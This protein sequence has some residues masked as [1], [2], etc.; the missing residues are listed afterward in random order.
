M[1]NNGNSKIDNEIIVAIG[2]IQDYL[3][4]KID[5]GGIK[6]KFSW[7]DTKKQV[8][9]TDVA[10]SDFSTSKN[11]YKILLVNPGKRK[12]YFVMDEDVNI[13]NLKNLF[14]KLASGD[15]R[16]KMFPKNEFPELTE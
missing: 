11:G 8:K 9:F 1:N 6:Y 14:D 13:D 16:F 15:L 7:L 12:R 2:E 5:Y 3:S 4:P 10:G